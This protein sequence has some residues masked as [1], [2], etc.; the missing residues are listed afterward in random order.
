MATPSWTRPD[1]DQIDPPVPA[2]H[3]N[4]LPVSTGRGRDPREAW[5]GEGLAQVRAILEFV[6]RPAFASRH[7]GVAQTSAFLDLGLRYRPGKGAGELLG[8]FQG[9]LDG[10][11]RARI[12]RG[13]DEIDGDR[14]FQDGVVRVVVGHHRVG[15]TEPPVTALAGAGRGDDLDD[16]G[17]HAG[18]YLARCLCR[19]VHTF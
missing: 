14:L 19:N 10:D 1:F 7:L 2:P 4:P 3:P 9:E 11:P 5:E 18:S 17:A 13:V 8:R 12:E 6:P 15:Q 16:R